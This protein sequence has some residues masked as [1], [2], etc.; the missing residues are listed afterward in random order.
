M[1]FHELY[2]AP[3]DQVNGAVCSVKE[4]A[5]LLAR[6]RGLYPAALENAIDQWIDHEEIPL[7]EVTQATSIP[8][9]PQNATQATLLFKH[10]NAVKKQP[11]S[12]KQTCFLELEESRSHQGSSSGAFRAGVI[13]LHIRGV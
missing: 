1:I 7:T 12:A 10:S 9:Q 2:L 6:A 3:R 4:A 13:L 8:I 5:K 11:E